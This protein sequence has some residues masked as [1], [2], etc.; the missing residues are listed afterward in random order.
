MNEP[1]WT[2]EQKVLIQVAEWEMSVIL[3]RKWLHANT[4]SMYYRWRVIRCA[5]LGANKEDDYLPVPNL[6]INEFPDDIVFSSTSERRCTICHE[7]ETI[8]SFLES[9]FSQWRCVH[10][11]PLC[12]NRGSGFLWWN[13]DKDKG[14][15]GWWFLGSAQMNMVVL[16]T[17]RWVVNVMSSVN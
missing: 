17:Y 13:L 9:Y 1:W 2:F 12:T 10:A 14:Y 11:S 3:K 8:T 6:S 5:F 15:E 16:A 7:A 4:V